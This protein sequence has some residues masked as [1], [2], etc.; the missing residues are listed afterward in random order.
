MIAVLDTSP[1]NCVT[2]ITE[3]ELLTK[4]HGTVV[5]QGSSVKSF[6]DQPDLKSFGPGLANDPR[7]CRVTMARPRRLALIDAQTLS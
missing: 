1:M 7:Q 6:S 3:I 2:L 5:I 4:M